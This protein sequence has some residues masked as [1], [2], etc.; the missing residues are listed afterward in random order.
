M[1]K[2]FFALA[3]ALTVFGAR[4]AE[5]GDV[6]LEMADGNAIR[7]Y[8]RTSFVNNVTFVEI[9]AEPKGERIRY[10]VDQIARIVFDAGAVYVRHDYCTTLMGK[11]AKNGLMRQ[12][13]LGKGIALYSAYVEG[14]EPVGGTM[15]YRKVALTNY[16]IAL[17]DDPAVFVAQD[18]ATG[19]AINQGSFNRT[20]LAA[21][22]N[23][24]YK[25]YADFARRIKNK[26]FETKHSPVEIVRAWEASYGGQAE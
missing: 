7:G 17:G 24:R 12:E 16:Y 8:N 26:E 15:R 20:Q 19:G 6:T 23:K 2:I 21:Y 9:S 5:N 14:Q 3:A 1:K 4:A 18:Y 22:F 25:E 10:D 13:Y 11:K